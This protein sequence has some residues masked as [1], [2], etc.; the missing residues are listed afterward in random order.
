[1]L[2]SIWA[3]NKWLVCIIGRVDLDIKDF[4]FAATHRFYKKSVAPRWLKAQVLAQDPGLEKLLLKV[5]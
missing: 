3:S 5:V 4:S 1:M 2:L